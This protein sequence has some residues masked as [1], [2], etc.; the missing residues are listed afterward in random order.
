[1]GRGE[2]QTSPEMVAM[3]PGMNQQAAAAAAATRNSSV[4]SR[5]LARSLETALKRL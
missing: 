5:L 2:G 4:A 1:M 3:A